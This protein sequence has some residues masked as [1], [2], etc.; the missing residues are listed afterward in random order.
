[1]GIEMNKNEALILNPRVNRRN[2]VSFDDEWTV[3][4][5]GVQMEDV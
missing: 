4:V 1:M 3:K 5:E 2:D